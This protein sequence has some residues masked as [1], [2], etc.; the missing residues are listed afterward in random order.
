MH[1]NTNWLLD[2]QVDRISKGL[3]CKVVMPYWFGVDTGYTGALGTP[4][5]WNVSLSSLL[6]ALQAF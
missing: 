2:E 1:A 3:G 5:Q 6:S 4:E